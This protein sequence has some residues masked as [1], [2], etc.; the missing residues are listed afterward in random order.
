M[1]QQFHFQIFIKKM[2]THVHK[3]TGAQMFMATPSCP[4]TENNPDILQSDAG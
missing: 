4:K 1:T 2:K 3:Q